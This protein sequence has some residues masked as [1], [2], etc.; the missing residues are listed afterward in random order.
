MSAGTERGV[1]ARLCGTD[2]ETRG[3][4]V[5]EEG[6]VCQP[7]DATSLDVGRCG[8]SCTPDGSYSDATCPEGLRNCK[9]SAVLEE[10]TAGAGDSAPVVVELDAVCSASGVIQ[11]GDACPGVDCA[12]GAECIFPRSAQED[13]VSTLLSPYFGGAGLSPTCRAY[14]DPFD[15]QRATRRCGVGETCLVNF[16]W[17]AD[18]GHC[19]AVVE[20]VQPFQ[21]CSRPGESC[22]EDSVCV[23][24]GGAPFCLRLCEYTGGRSS[25]VFDQST[26]P[27]GLQCGP[28]VNDVGFCL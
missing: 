28:L 27:A 19:A 2:E 8:Q 21:A 26:C 17:S 14:C 9:P 1:C 12:P 10:D 3:E 15:A 11:E 23:I 18:V 22:G 5:C 16:P 25:M 4:L 7:I 20:D 13:L 6:Q 24:D